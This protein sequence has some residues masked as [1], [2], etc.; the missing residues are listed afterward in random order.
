MDAATRTDTGDERH[1]DRSQD[2]LEQQLDPVEALRV[3]DAGGAGENSA[4]QRGD[5]TDDQRQ[6]Q[7]DVLLARYDQATQRADDKTDDERGDDAEGASRGAE[8]K[9]VVPLFESIDA[10][11]D[12]PINTVACQKCQPSC[13]NYRTL[14]KIQ[15]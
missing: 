4:Q 8:P 12:S 13:W 10:R 9:I 5:D 1:A 3:G 11:N 6:P 15:N 2:N 14:A 7:R